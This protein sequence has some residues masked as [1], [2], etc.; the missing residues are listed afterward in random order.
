[1]YTLAGLSNP[2]TGWGVADDTCQAVE[3]VSRL[4]GPDWFR[5]GD[6]DLGTNLMRSLLLHSGQSLTQ[7]TSYLCRQLGVTHTLLPMTDAPVR[8]IVDTDQG[9]LGFQEYFVRE[10]WQPVVSRIRFEGAETAAPSAEVSSALEQA[11]LIIVGPSNPFLSIDPILAVPGIRSGITASCAP[12]V[13]LSPIIQGQAVKGPAAKL[14]AELGVDVSPLGVAR[15]FSD[16][17]DG[18]ILD[19]ADADARP[20]IEALGIRTTAQRTLM[21]NL[22]DKVTLAGII[23]DWA[24]ESFT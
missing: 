13:A 14:M 12:C 4:G 17:L 9:E 18:L 15:H 24:E 16:L 8:T 20:P 19:A 23:L 6:R 1:M 5:L 22:S 2:I 10:R 3:M 11:A 21:Q 7:V